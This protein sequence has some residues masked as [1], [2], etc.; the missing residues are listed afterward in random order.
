[1]PTATDSRSTRL[2]AAAD[3]YPATKTQTPPQPRSHTTAA[4]T[5]TKPPTPN[6]TPAA[7][8]RQSLIPPLQISPK[9]RQQKHR[10]LRVN[11]PRH[12]HHRLNPQ[13]M[14]RPPQSPQPRRPIQNR[15]IPRTRSIPRPQ[16]PQ[17]YKIQ[18]HH[19]NQMLQQIAKMI[20]PRRKPPDLIIQ[21]PAQPVQR[22]IPPRPLII[23]ERPLQILDTQTRDMRIRQNLRIIIPIHKPR[24]APDKKPPHKSNTMPQASKKTNA[25][26]VSVRPL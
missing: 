21:L 8:A 11:P 2:R 12:P 4:N 6:T 13:R 25:I 9:R 23:R 14:N 20:P 24:A 22:L 18:Q 15:A 7:P 19:A 1:M 3:K 5:Q 10:A 26:V 16:N 17:H